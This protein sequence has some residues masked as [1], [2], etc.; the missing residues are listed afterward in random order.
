MPAD[1]AWLDRVLQGTAVLSGSYLSGS[2]MTISLITFPTMIDTVL[3]PSHLLQQWVGMFY[4]GHRIHPTMAVATLSIYLY[5]AWRQRLVNAAWTRLLGAGLVTFLMTPFTWFIIRPMNTTI[6][7]LAS[8]S[9]GDKVGM[10]EA[11]RLVRKWSWLHLTRSL[12]PLMGAVLGL[13]QMF[14]G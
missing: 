2:M 6:S 7:R 13:R 4:Y 9:K 1:R 3:T 14:A 11:Q 10:V 5:A 8:D 12:F